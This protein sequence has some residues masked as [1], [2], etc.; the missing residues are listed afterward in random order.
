MG[1]LG[2]LFGLLI[3]LP[4]LLGLLFGLLGLLFGLNLD[5]LCLIKR[6]LLAGL[7]NALNGIIV[8]EED[9]EDLVGLNDFLLGDFEGDFEGDLDAL[10]NLL[11]S[12]L[13]ILLYASVGLFPKNIFFN[14]DF[15]VEFLV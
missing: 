8:V 14:S 10:L 15:E 11:L 13:L 12:L 1:L 6:G 9:K 2:L 7:P 4:G 5:D 3:F